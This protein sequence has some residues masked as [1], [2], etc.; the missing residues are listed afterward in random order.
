[1]SP[2]PIVLVI[3]SEMSAL[4][5]CGDLWEPPSTAT[6]TIPC[7]EATSSSPRFQRAYALHDIYD[8]MV[9]D[10]IDVDMFTFLLRASDAY[11]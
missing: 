3:C 5:R 6:G 9:S 4:T 11:I 10:G 7:P 1:M 8:L 2:R